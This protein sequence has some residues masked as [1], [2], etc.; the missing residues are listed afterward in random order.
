MNVEKIIESIRSVIKTSS[1]T[2]W[3]ENIYIPRDDMEEFISLLDSSEY[4]IGTITGG[5]FYSNKG[6]KEHVY[7]RSGEKINDRRWHNAF[8]AADKG[9]HRRCET[10]VYGTPLPKSFH[11]RAQ[12]PRSLRIYTA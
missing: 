5:N 8:R 2:N 11:R 10:V 7:Y 6:K 9:R 3:F 4:L 12:F 1:N